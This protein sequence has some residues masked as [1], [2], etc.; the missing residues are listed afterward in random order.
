[1]PDLQSRTANGGTVE[2]VK[3]GTWR[4]GMPPGPGGE[5]RWAQLDDHLGLPRSQFPWKSP[6]R[7]SLEARSLA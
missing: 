7:L 4:L 6:F 1:M 5:Y 3:P 2:P